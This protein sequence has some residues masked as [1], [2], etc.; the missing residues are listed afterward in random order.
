VNIDTKTSNKVQAQWFIAIISATQEVEIGRIM[1]QEQ[2]G[3][4]YQDPS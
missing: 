2:P 1:A 3:Q 4:S